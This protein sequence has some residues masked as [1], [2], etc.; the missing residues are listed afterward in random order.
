MSSPNVA[1]PEVTYSPTILLDEPACVNNALINALKKIK[2]TTALL[3]I[4]NF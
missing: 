2:I 1:R 3:K 4:K